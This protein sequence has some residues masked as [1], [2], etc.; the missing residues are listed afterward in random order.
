MNI[1]IF[2]VWSRRL[3]NND[4]CTGGFQD[5][6]RCSRFISLNATKGRKRI[7]KILKPEKIPKPVNEW[8]VLFNLIINRDYFEYLSCEVDFFSVE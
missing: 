1:L 6:C 4:T 2:R 5:C 8:E 3:K 7:K